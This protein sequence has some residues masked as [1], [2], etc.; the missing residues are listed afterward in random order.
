MR[1]N[2]AI[3][4]AIKTLALLVLLSTA[5]QTKAQETKTPYPNIAPIDQYLMDRTAEIALARSAAPDSISHD[6][7]VLVLGRQGY[8]TAAE[9][10]N[11]FVCWVARSWMGAF[12]WPEFWNPKVRAA[13]CLNPQAARSLVPVLLLRSKM[14][15][16]DR[17]KEEILSALKTAYEKKQLPDLETGAMDYMMSKSSYLTDW[18][19]HNMPHLMFFTTVKDAQDWGSGAAGSPV[20]AAPYWI[21]SPSDPSQTKGLPPILVFLVMA[22]TWSDGTPMAH[23]E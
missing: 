22:P 2:K 23:N 12:D 6:A 8:E 9:G 10:K 4:I 19:G 7:T 11:G 5:H 18:G 3:S 1:K 17:S 21:F 14:I 15:M 13:D 20:M 16:A